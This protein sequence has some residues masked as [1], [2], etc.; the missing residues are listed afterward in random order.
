VP[1]LLPT[2]MSNYP[3]IAATMFI[4]SGFIAGIIVS[5]MV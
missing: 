4:L 5:M 3:H 1:E 2:H